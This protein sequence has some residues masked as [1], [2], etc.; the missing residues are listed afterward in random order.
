MGFRFD[1]E[2]KRFVLTAHDTDA[3]YLVIDGVARLVD[4]ETA[5]PNGRLFSDE[6]LIPRSE[7]G[8]ITF[9]AD[10]PG[11]FLMRDGGTGAV[12]LVYSDYS[13]VTG[14]WP[15]V[16]LGAVK[17]H[18][19]SPSAMDRYHFDWG[20]VLEAGNGNDFEFDPRRRTSYALWH[21]LLGLPLAT[22]QTLDA[23]S[24]F[25]EMNQRYEERLS[26]RAA[27]K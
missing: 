1:L 16:C 17:R 7:A 25:A 21:L 2:G 13:L 20:K 3:L 5:Y 6:G 23:E 22:P 24:S 9:G 14:Q 19:T 8:D 4:G 10:M 11:A 18:V 12:W 27:E 15:E 26:K